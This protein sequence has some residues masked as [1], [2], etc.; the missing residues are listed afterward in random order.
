MTTNFL[1]RKISVFLYLVIVGATASAMETK[2]QNAPTLTAEN[3]S[4]RVLKLVKN[5]R[6]LKDISAKSIK[7]SMGIKVILN[8]ED[9]NIY[10]FSGKISDSDWFYSLISLSETKGGTPHRLEFSFGEPTGNY[11]D[12]KPV[13]SIDFENYQKELTAA[14]F[15]VTPYYGEHNRL[16]WHNFLRNNVSVQI[17]A[18]GESAENIQQKCVRMLILEVT[19]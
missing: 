14:G 4:R 13:C 16:L 19:D 7:K 10:G 15:S 11:P 6:K 2:A 18:N 1:Y 8:S 5:V 9:K 17:T 3:I 12:M